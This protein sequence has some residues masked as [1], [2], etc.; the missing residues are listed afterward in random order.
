MKKLKNLTK[1]KKILLGVIIIVLVVAIVITAVVIKKKNTAGTTMPTY[2]RTVTLGYS[3]LQE[4][5]VASGTIESQNTSTVSANGNYQ[6]SKINYSVGDYV[7]EGD[8]IIELDKTSVNKQI[9]KLQKQVSDSEER[10]QDNYDDAVSS[11]DSI[12]SNWYDSKSTLDSAESAYNDAVAKVKN[13]QTAYDVALK[14]YNAEAERLIAAGCTIK[15]RQV[16]QSCTVSNTLADL[17][18]AL[19][20]AESNLNTV[21]T[22]ENYDELK[23]AYESASTKYNELTNQLNSANSKVSDTYDEL[24]DGVENDQLEDLYDSLEDYELTAKSSGQI[25]S[26]NAVL[27]SSANG[28]L[29]TIQDTSKLKISLTIDEYDIFKVELGQKATIET[30]ASDI[31]YEG[32]VSQISPVATGSMG[33]SGF[34]IEV[35]VTSEDVSKLLIGMFAEVTIIINEMD[36]NFSV[37]I[38][39]VETKDNGISVIYVENEAGEF[40]EVEVTT[41]ENNGYYIEIFGDTLKEGMKVRASANADEAQINMVEDEENSEMSGFNFGQMGGG[42]NMPQGGGDFPSGGGGGNPPSGGPGF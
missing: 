4:T 8:V 34:E 19:E 24:S 20:N 2:T 7:K 30:D 5:I 16:D 15:N 25:T 33:S 28:T 23:K 1:G 13:C 21:K 3:N 29:A 22:A 10:L 12:W 41:G 32:V 17:A 11:K 38:D 27:G 42:G 40:E 36:N 35:E 26:L 9:T 37:P 14:A 31:V 18:K 39:A 6:V